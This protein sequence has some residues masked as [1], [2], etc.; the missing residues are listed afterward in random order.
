MLNKKAVA[1]QLRDSGVSVILYAGGDFQWDQCM[2]WT[3]EQQEDET[4]F[5]T[6]TS[7]FQIYPHTIDAETTRQG[8]YL[9]SFISLMLKRWVEKEFEAAGL[10]S[11]STG[12]KIMIEL[13]KI[14]LIGL[15]NDRTIVTGLHSRQ[16]DILESL[17]WQVELQT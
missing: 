14:R 16:Q 11:V 17:K 2:Q 3:F 10:L 12:Q 1:R 15:G 9:V 7:R 5:S 6:V 8:I 13:A 4:F